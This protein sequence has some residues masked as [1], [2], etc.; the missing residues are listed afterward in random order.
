[1]L[2]N[3]TIAGCGLTGMLSALALATKNIP[4]TILERRSSQEK[5][6][7][8]D[9]RT[10][11]LTASSRKFFE[12]IDIWSSLQE[13]VGPINDIYVVDNKSPD[14]LHFAS[15]E[16]A[17]DE[18]MGHLIQ[19]IDFKKTLFNLVQKNELITIIE[20][21]SYKVEKNS[22]D[23]CS[24]LL[25]DAT[26]HNCDLLLV[27]DGRYSSVRQRYFS[28]NFEKSYDQSA[29]TFLVK[30][31]KP[32]EG[33]AVEHF[34]QT[35]PFA[36]LPLKEANMSSIVWTIE[37]DMQQLLENLPIDEFSEI[38]QDNF[39][40]FLGKIQIQGEIAGFPLKAYEADKYF[41]K[42]IVLIADTAH[43]IHP[44][45]GQGLN[46]G[47]KDINC[48]VSLLLEFG[49]S[50][51]MLNQYQKFRKTDNS[52]MLE[53]TDTINTVFSNKSKILQVTRKVGFQAIE[54]ITP[55]KKLLIKY[56]MGRR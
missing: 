48:F 47:I 15:S 52:N 24:L 38:V 28:S 55:F 22:Q 49:V 56:A 45:A 53:I 6:F 36:I 51:D 50:D 37:S 2:P 31:E 39:G 5:T 4:T 35:G 20:N 18:I 44:L 21:C 26:T 32:H 25:N 30:H 17:G 19:N 12:E 11:A 41:N 40:E 8:D 23:G 29:L 10:T 16:L 9:V 1:M 42:R 34:M 33:T 27:C 13:F 43:V 3:I 14:M 7:F 46:Q 54:K